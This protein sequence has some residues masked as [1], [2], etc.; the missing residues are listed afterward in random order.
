VLTSLIMAEQGVLGNGE[1]EP[2][3][4]SYLAAAILLLL[5]LEAEGQQRRDPPSGVL[6][7]N[8]DTLNTSHIYNHFSL[9][10]CLALIRS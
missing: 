9:Y 5:R 3:N 10:S 8:P 7:A 2:I 4:D 1:L 6:I